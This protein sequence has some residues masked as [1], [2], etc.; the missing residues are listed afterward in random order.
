MTPESHHSHTSHHSGGPQA[1]R[2][3]DSVDSA[4]HQPPPAPRVP[5]TVRPFL[6]RPSGCQYTPSA[7]AKSRRRHSHYIVH[8]LVFI[9]HIL[10]EG[11]SHT[12]L[13]KGE[14]RSS[15]TRPDS[16][17]LEKS[18]QTGH[19][20][21][22]GRSRGTSPHLGLGGGGGCGGRGGGGDS[23][24]RRCGCGDGGGGGS[25]GGVGG[26]GGLACSARSHRLDCLCLPDLR[27][28]AWTCRGRV[29]DALCRPRSAPSPAPVGGCVL[30]TP[31]P[32]PSA[33]SAVPRP[34][35]AP[36]S[37]RSSSPSSTATAPRA[38]GPALSAPRAPAASGS[39]R[40]SLPL[41]VY[42]HISPKV[43]TAASATCPSPY[44]RISQYLPVGAGSDRVRRGASRGQG[45]GVLCVCVCV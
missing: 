44:P 31:P 17:R 16:R 15:R 36:A 4:T 41:P 2:A 5:S 21:G 35:L 18:L 9:T 26:G 38:S 10:R 40:V 14:S 37:C 19:R 28:V 23:G 45:R 34:R 1:Q 13:L 39:D 20:V 25:V 8:T 43:R 12:Q 29:M 33:I 42:P 3:T 24:R 30:P 7:K 22:W 11:N 27:V 32:H 6:R